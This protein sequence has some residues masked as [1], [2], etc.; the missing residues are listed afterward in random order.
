MSQPFFIAS[1]ALSSGLLVTPCP[2]WKSINAQQSDT[3][4]P[5][6]PHL[7]RRMSTSSVLLPQQG[8]PLTRLYAPMTLSTSASLTS[9]SNAGK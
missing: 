5:A 4:K 6:K 7:L 1:A 9:A 3:T 2:V 8:S